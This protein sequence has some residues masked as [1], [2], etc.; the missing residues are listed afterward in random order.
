MSDEHIIRAIDRL[1]ERIAVIESV[2]IDIATMVALKQTYLETHLLNTLNDEGGNFVH[3]S[4][5]DAATQLYDLAQKK[6]GET[7]E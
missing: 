7:K 3:T 2:L 5:S 6:K 1:G 4:A